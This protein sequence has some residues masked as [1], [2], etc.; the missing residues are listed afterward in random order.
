MSTVYEPKA[1]IGDHIVYYSD[2]SKLRAHYPGWS[3]TRSVDEIFEEFA[4]ATHTLARTEASALVGAAGRAG[5]G[6][7][8]G[9][10]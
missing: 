9:T 7:D 1:R 3:I 6:P 2:L 8:G 4:R 10:S 5:H